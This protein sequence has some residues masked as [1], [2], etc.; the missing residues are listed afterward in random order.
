MSVSATSVLVLGILTLTGC[1]TPSGSPKIINTSS[2]STNHINS[3][4]N[5]ETRS[6]QSQENSISVQMPQLILENILAFG[7][8]IEL[9]VT[10]GN[11][12]TEYFHP[13]I[14]N[15]NPQQ[16][17][18]NLKNIKS[19][20]YPINKKIILDSGPISDLVISPLDKGLKL[21][22]TFRQKVVSFKSGIAGG[23]MIVFQFQ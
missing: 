14:I 22:F 1:G 12:A 3:N 20:K 16:F 18:V 2:N 9:V 4:I 19:G 6:I 8:S 17:V 10:R 5:S 21:V 15:T 23:T 13:Q 11:L 7:S